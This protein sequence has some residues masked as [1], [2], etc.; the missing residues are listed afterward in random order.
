MIPPQSDPRKRE[1]RRTGVDVPAPEQLRAGRL[2]G[3]DHSAPQ[4]DGRVRAAALSVV[5][6]AQQAGQG[7]AEGPRRAGGAR[8]LHGQVGLVDRSVG[9]KGRP[10]A[11]VVDGPAGEWQPAQHQHAREAQEPEKVRQ[12]ARLQDAHHGQEGQG[13]GQGQGQA[14]HGLDGG[15]HVE[16]LAHPGHGPAAQTAPGEGRGGPGRDQRG[17]GRVRL[18]ELVAQE[19]GQFAERESR[20]LRTAAATATAAIGQ[21]QSRGQCAQRE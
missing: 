2:P 20:V 11:Q 6:V 19:F 14:G 1:P 3:P 18:R 5:Q 7:E 8:G 4:R 21:A 15:Q 16:C 9:R 10:E 12:V 17:R 13:Q